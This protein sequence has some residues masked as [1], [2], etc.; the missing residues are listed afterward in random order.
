MNIKHT[1][2]GGIMAVGLVLGGGAAAFA[3]TTYP[4]EGG[5]WNYGVVAGVHLYSDYFHQT[6]CHGS[7][8][9]NDWGLS[10]SPDVA[11]GVWSNN[12]QPTT[13]IQNNRAYYRTC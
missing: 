8:T 9:R 7:S 4:P 3:T 10:S 11:G 1:L 13:S 2:S 5:T 6:V 12:S